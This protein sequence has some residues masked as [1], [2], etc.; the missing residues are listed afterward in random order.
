MKVYYNG[1]IKALVLHSRGNALAFRE[2]TEGNC[3]IE[4]LAESQLPPIEEFT[5]LIHREVFGFLGLIKFKSVVYLGFITGRRLVGAIRDSES[6]YQIVDTVFISLNGEVA[7]YYKEDQ[8]QSIP[9]SGA[10]STSSNTGE[11][12]ASHIHS[13]TKL[14]ASGTFYYSPDTDLSLS[15]KDR[16]AGNDSYSKRFVW[17]NGLVDKLT[18]FRLR[19]HDSRKAQFD[20]GLFYITIIRGFV[21]QRIIEHGKMLIISKQDTKKNGQLFG[22]VG[23][24]DDGNVANFVETEIVITF[25]TI[26][27]SYLLISGNVPLFWKLD[28]HLISTKLDLKRSID[29]SLHTFSKFFES[30]YYQ[31]GNIF[32]LDALSSKGSQPELSQKFQESIASLAEYSPEIP[33]SY[34]KLLSQSLLKPRGNESYYNSLADDELALEEL[35]HHNSLT[36]NLETSEILCSQEGVI[37]LATLF[38]IE[39]ANFLMEK[40]SEH[41]LSKIFDTIPDDL[42]F[43]HYELWQSNGTALNKLAENYNNSIKAK[44]KTGGIMGKVAGQS[45]RLMPGASQHT[46]SGKQRQF[47]RL[48]GGKN[49]ELQVDLIDPVHDYVHEGLDA[50]V[51]EYLQKKDLLIYTVTYNVNGVKFNGDLSEFLFPEKEFNSY[52]VVV[53][54]LEEVIELTPSKVMSIDPEIRNHWE[55]RLLNTLNPDGNKQYSLLR[56]EQLG[57]ILLLL[58]ANND[59]AHLINDIETSVK[60]TGFKGMSANKGGVAISFNYSSYSKLCFIASHLAA[61][62][63]NLL[64]RH[65]DYKTISKGIKFS[66]NTTIFNCGILVWMGDLNYRIQ[67]PNELVRKMLTLNKPSPSLKPMDRRTSQHHE[68]I[69]KLEISDKGENDT[70]MDEKDDDDYMEEEDEEQSSSAEREFEEGELNDESV[71]STLLSET[72]D[73]QTAI[74]RLFE[75]DQLNTQMSSGKTFPFFDEMEI[76]FNPTYKFDKGT[77]TYDTSEKQRI[78][79]WTDRILTYNKNKEVI[80]QL[81]YNSIPSYVFSDHKPVYGIFLAH[82]DLIDEAKKR[83]IEKELY[84]LRK[85]KL[86][87]DSILTK[88]NKELDEDVKL[89]TASK[90]GLPPPSGKMNRWWRSSEPTNDGSNVEVKSTKITFKEMDTDPLVRINPQLPLNPFLKTSQEDF[91]C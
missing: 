33:V 89:T 24:D 41:Y 59:S 20:Q 58:Y 6:V 35:D 5:D 88:S 84:L 26:L 11:Y 73:V 67:L 37:F 78:P 51:G 27:Y 13:I 2:T 8:F 32:V 48:L 21:E 45:K 72:N 47:D 39:R 40:V 77:D 87:N 68:L 85:N 80:Q 17:N 4:F 31:Y 86:R 79:A 18:E 25:K 42:W 43:A 64:E 14:L 70:T 22:P 9:M 66:K 75:F 36:L 65:A 81:K 15:M 34:K 30:L 90:H 16:L 46:S 1:A 29:S 83:E 82:L 56:T 63:H 10:T 19:L 57:G 71:I 53:V 54:G 38:S 28:S 50:R 61:G 69:S 91:V 60:K 52:D 23:M 12:V 74:V 49:K 62:H 7:T 44:N 55:S 3:L 76:K